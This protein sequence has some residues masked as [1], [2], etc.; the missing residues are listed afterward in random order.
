M[1]GAWVVLVAFVALAFSVEPSQ[2][3]FAECNSDYA[4]TF[5]V[6]AGD[7]RWSP[8][9][10]ECVEYFRISVS[11]PRGPRWIRGIG[12]INVGA[13]LTP[14]AIRAV[15]AGARRSAERMSSLGDYRLDNTSILMAFD[16]STPAELSDEHTQAWKEGG[17]AAWTMPG[18]GPEGAECHVTLFLLGAWSA[19][20][21]IPYM[22]A[23]E[24][25][26]CVQEASLS[27]AQHTALGEWWIEG[28]RF[29]LAQAR[30]EAG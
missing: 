18:Q 19:A 15:E 24:L 11:T 6:N 16:V 8:G 3:Q 29:K 2:A 12:D 9:T 25:F 21:E 27:E 26:H 17:A 10:I 28:M 23:H 14:G 1:R 4:R 7:T 13:L 22:T 30:Q 5:E 20:V